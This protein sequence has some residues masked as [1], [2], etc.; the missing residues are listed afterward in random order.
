MPRGVA[1]T[2]YPATASPW[3]PVWAAVF[4]AAAALR[5]RR[6]AEGRDPETGLRAHEIDAPP[7]TESSLQARG[8]FV[9]IGNLDPCIGETQAT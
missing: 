7:P 8:A 5:A 4:E 2:A 6:A 9:C 1:K 3:L